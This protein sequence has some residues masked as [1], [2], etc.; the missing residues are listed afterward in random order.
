MRSFRA[1]SDRDLVQ[2]GLA[3]D[4]IAFTRIAAKFERGG[5][6][7]SVEVILREAP[8]ADDPTASTLSK[9]IR[10]NDGARRAIDAIGVLTA[11]SFAPQDLELV[12]GAPLLRRRYLDVTISQEDRRYC[13]SL[14]Q[15]NRVVVQRNSLLRS[16]RERGT[17]VDELHFWNR[18]MIASG[19][20]VVFRRLDTLQ[21][22]G[23][24]AKRR[25]GELSGRDEALDLS[26]RSTIFDGLLTGPQDLDEI[27][28]TY[29]ARIED[30]LRREIALGASVVG[31]HRD[32]LV[33]ALGGHPLADFGSRGQQRTVA[34]ALKLAEAEHLRQQTGESPI[35][36]LDDV[37]SELDAS[38]RSRVVESILLDQQVFLTTADPTFLAPTIPGATWLHVDRGRVQRRAADAVP[39]AG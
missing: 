9:R 4:P 2:W 20:Y 13:R 6:V 37:L 36:L 11:V 24:M 35:L 21:R 5:D 10:V 33:L 27:T 30:V 38:R 16:I 3:D 14:A 31:P 12:D 34:L 29:E 39:A 23:Q 1:G 25:Y 17:K 15:Y 32:D 19:A 18:E 26:Y 28:A 22:L 7:E 8:K